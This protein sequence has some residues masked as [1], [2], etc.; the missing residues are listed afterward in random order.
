L[1][2]VLCELL[3]DPERTKEIGHAA[4][5]TAQQLRGASAVIIDRLL[6]TSPHAGK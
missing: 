3:L 2:S 4:R 6:V 5:H 1:G